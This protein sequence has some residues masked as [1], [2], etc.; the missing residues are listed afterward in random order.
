MRP[1]SPRRASAGAAVRGARQ[2]GCCFLPPL[3]PHLI[4]ATGPSIR[5]SARR[6]TYP[7][8]N[9]QRNARVP[10]TV[11]P[12]AT[13]SSIGTNER[14]RRRSG[15][16]VPNPKAQPLFLVA[17]GHHGNRS[18]LVSVDIYKLGLCLHLA[19]RSAGFWCGRC[20]DIPVRLLGPDPCTFAATTHFRFVKSA[21]LLAAPVSF[22]GKAA[23]YLCLPFTPGALNL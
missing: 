16:G 19:T 11:S 21:M 13:A 5:C 12:E 15:S 14:T 10:C 18:P 20:P 22:V 4:P 2:T 7:R 3:P 1:V 9:S 17:D 23:T 6:R 8:P